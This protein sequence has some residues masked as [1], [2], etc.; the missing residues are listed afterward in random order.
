MKRFYSYKR[1]ILSTFYQVSCAI[2]MMALLFVPSIPQKEVSEDNY[3]TVYL[4][5]IEVGH[6]GNLNTA[7]NIL[8]QARRKIADKS[9]GMF[10]SEAKLGWEGKNVLFGRLDEQQE[11][12][13][14]MIEILQAS[15]VE[16]LESAYTVK[17]NDYMVNLSG[18]EEVRELLGTVLEP[19]DKS[20]EFTVALITDPKRELNVLTT[21]VVRQEE[22]LNEEPSSKNGAGVEQYFAEVFAEVDTELYSSTFSEL[23]YG[24]VDLD[25]ADIVEIVECWLPAE[26]ITTLDDAVA[27]ITVDLEKEQVY[28]VKNGDTLL[29]IAE[30][31]ELSVAELLEINS[32]LESEDAVLRVGD[33]LK[34]TVAE[35]VLSIYKTERIYSEGSYDAATEY[36]DNDDW[37]SS[38]QV[39]LRQPSAGVRKTASLV[40]SRNDVVIGT[41][42]IKEEIGIEAVAKLVE[43]G[44][45]IPPTYIKPLS[46]GRLTSNYGGR[47]A[48]TKGAST[49]HKGTDWAVPT[50]TAVM[51]SGSGVVT[52]AGWASG[53]GNVVYI[54]HEDGKETRYGHLSKILVSVGQ[55]VK[56]GEKIALSGNT[57]RST[58]PHLH[59]EIRI[60]GEA[61]NSL[62]YL[63]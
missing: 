37:Y 34:I 47:T 60:N 3:F 32:G 39:I 9:G 45:K 28:E 58:G 44:T 61:V 54:S 38:Q 51:A 4:N 41:E 35:P 50:G 12:R 49:N 26:E 18:S 33:E 15:E 36:L 16:I 23:D 30:E 62:E 43:R 57:G 52:R 17:I 11:I 29:Q 55:K 20:D 8:A 48:P 22:L 14:K 63:E 7:R 5:G 31:H 56:Q 24:L 21:D 6:T 13:D 59:F 46:G 19:Y 27:Q 2:V 1:V 10:Y 42:I 53:Y 40:K 25:F